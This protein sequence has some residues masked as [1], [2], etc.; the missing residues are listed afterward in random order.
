MREES[1]ATFNQAVMPA[2]AITDGFYSHSAYLYVNRIVS[3]R[4]VANATASVLG[5]GDPTPTDI[6]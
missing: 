3:T 4:D 5:V 1:S 6:L 2:V